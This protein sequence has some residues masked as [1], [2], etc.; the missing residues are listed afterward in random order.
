MTLEEAMLLAQN[1]V[2]ASI[3]DQSGR[4]IVNSLLDH[5]LNAPHPGAQYGM[6][7]IAITP[8]SVLEFLPGLGTVESVK[9]AEGSDNPWIKALGYGGAALDVA[10]PL[11]AGK[12]AAS[13]PLML[14]MASRRAKQVAPPGLPGRLNAVDQPR[15]DF[16]TENAPP[17][18]TRK[19]VGKNTYRA[20]AP[21]S[22]KS[23][24]D[25]TLAL[26]RYLSG[27]ESGAIGRGWYDE[28]SGMF[29]ADVGNIAG[30]RPGAKEI[31]AG[32]FGTYSPRTS[33]KA[34]ELARVR[35]NNQWVTGA[36]I[37][38]A[39]GPRNRAA[40]LMLNE[41]RFPDS[42]RYKVDTFTMSSAGYQPPRG[43]HDF[44]DANAWGFD[45][46]ETNQL[47]NAQHRWMD[48]MADK[49]VAEANRRKLGGFDDWNHERLQAA[50]WVKHKA[51]ETGK[52]P[53]EII[54]EMGD[55]REALSAR[56]YSEAIPSGEL[57]NMGAMDDP[58]R[59]AYTEMYASKF[60]NPEGQN[61][62]AHQQGLLSPTE[63]IARGDW[64]GGTTP[65]IVT[66]VLADPGKGASGDV[67]SAWSQEAVNFH[68]ALRGLLGGQ[69]DVATSYIRPAKRVGDV[70]AAKIP[71][72]HKLSDTERLTYKRIIES[73][74]REAG[75]DGGIIVNYGADNSL[76]VKYLGEPGNKDFRKILN[77]ISDGR[78][79]LGRDSGDLLTWADQYKPSEYM[80]MLQNPRM[81]ESIEGMLPGI[82]NDIAKDV[83]RL[84]L[85]DK[86]RRVY[87]KALDIM[88]RE[89][90]PGIEKA[91]KAGTLP[92]AFI[93]ALVL[94]ASQ[95]A[96]QPA[97][98]Q[99]QL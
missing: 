52:T 61:A 86:G 53:A 21:L 78:A 71:F 29:D 3:L 83:T 70:N 66:T 36:D 47:G 59:Q 17:G 68:G 6:P 23:A 33:V 55:Q 19:S 58:S 96:G 51:D 24:D 30:A 25:E 45:L 7:D 48:E 10:T 90:L 40:E 28:V 38:A 79:M 98:G 16:P 35:A 95:P 39:T 91:V 37:A 73:K 2:R 41:G 69:A 75:V 64:E 88:K 12:M 63:R 27:A 77:D 42:S 82:A 57:V 32:V 20:G 97:A 67:M 85:T 11:P 93:G 9:M 49:A 89:G 80:K 46:D 14:G 5:R 8:R 13:M 43:T 18:L 15:V 84:P 4:Q 74:L 54:K 72:T 60:R 31:Q 22:I 56:V 62:F 65:N 34:N 87:V 81:R 94:S 92:S 26:E 44:R 50:R 1:P 76:H 99:G